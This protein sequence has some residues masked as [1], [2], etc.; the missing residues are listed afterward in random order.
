[1]DAQYFALINLILKLQFGSISS[2]SLLLSLLGDRYLAK[3]YAWALSSYPDISTVIFMGDLI[4][5][6]S[7]AD[8]QMIADY[9]DRF[10]GLYP[11]REGVS[12]IY[13]PGDNDIGGEGADPVTINKM[14]RYL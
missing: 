14:D 10:H 5:E 1:M 13:I 7:E 2:F 8:D 6:G 4:D 12:M 3:S 9:A 11:A